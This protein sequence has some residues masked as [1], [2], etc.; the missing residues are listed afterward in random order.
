MTIS[1][2]QLLDAKGLACPMPLVKTKKAMEQLP[3]GQVLEIQA[4]DKGSIADM[5]SWSAKIGHTYLGNKTSGKSDVKPEQK[6]AVTM[7][8]D[9]LQALLADA[10]A[11]GAWTLL[12]VREPAEYAF[13]HIPQALSI[14]LGE[15]E[16]RA[17][18][19]DRSKPVYV[20]CRTGNRSDLASQQ[21]V[22]LGFDRVTNIIPGMSGWNGPLAVKE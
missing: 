3:E 20:V 4:T 10:S 9:E 21:L 15:L 1:V 6:H 22:E 11:A 13:G 2:N 8:N 7:S 19:L 16:R 14:P 12:D 17:A 5:K 18:E